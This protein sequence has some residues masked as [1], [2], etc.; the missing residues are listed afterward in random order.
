MES[1]GKEGWKGREGEEGREWEMRE[2]IKEGKEWEREKGGRGMGNG[3]GGRERGE[4]G[5]RK[6]R[7]G[8]GKGG[9]K[10][11]VKIDPSFFLC[12]ID[13]RE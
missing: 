9:R 1:E 8:K 10:G 12:W 7:G 5:L 3:K 11:R 4:V 13:H 6:G 2:T